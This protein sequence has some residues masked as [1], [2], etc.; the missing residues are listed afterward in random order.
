MFD[1]YTLQ[2][3]SPEDSAYLLKELLIIALYAGIFNNPHLLCTSTTS[4]LIA[5][6]LT[7]VH[8]KYLD[9]TAHQAS[10]ARTLAHIFNKLASL[11]NQIFLTDL[12]ATSF[13]PYLDTYIQEYLDTLQKLHLKMQ[14]K[15]AKLNQLIQTYHALSPKIMDG[16]AS[17]MEK[18]KFQHT[19]NKIMQNFQYYEQYDQFYNTFS[20][21][22]FND[23]LFYQRSNLWRQHSKSYTQQQK[24]NRTN[25]SY[26]NII[27]PNYESWIDTAKN[28]LNK[29]TYH[30]E[31][32]KI[33]YINK[34]FN[35]LSA[36]AYD[37]STNIENLNIIPNNIPHE[38]LLFLIAAL[39]LELATGYNSLVQ[40][41][42][43]APDTFRIGLREAIE[44]IQYRQQ[45]LNVQNIHSNDFHAA[46][47]LDNT[48]M[49]ILNESFN[50]ISPKLPVIPSK[51]DIK[52]SRFIFQTFNS[53]NKM[54]NRII[55]SAIRYNTQEESITKTKSAFNAVK[56]NQT[57]LNEKP[58]K[59]L[60]QLKANITETFQTFQ[61]QG[62]LETSTLDRLA[63]KIY[64]NFK[65]RHLFTRCLPQYQKKLLAFKNF[66]NTNFLNDEFKKH[67]L[68]KIC[69]MRSN[70]NWTN[71]KNPT[72]SFQKF[73]NN[74]SNNML[75]NS[76]F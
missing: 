36:A 20:D 47:I 51:S 49:E 12:K 5:F 42:S 11:Q 24:T 32:K 2:D 38:D 27:N 16:K 68:I 71:A 66:F 75:S 33:E 3:I 39:I 34:I 54:S 52:Q 59:S 41:M 29:L 67:A 65:K 43:N 25:L 55:Q 69:K 7:K 35:N 13:N 19:Y 58:R 18:L 56:F 72:H 9:K 64:Q 76:H 8:N 53:H 14:A 60:S 50:Q 6:S 73:Q 57:I 4:N 17:Y 10:K 23:V 45:I 22:R 26:A 30:T 61:N 48:S 15:E 62:L 46:S 37:G 1:K 74:L 31:D 44:Y 40:L 63:Y 28:I 70:F 21:L